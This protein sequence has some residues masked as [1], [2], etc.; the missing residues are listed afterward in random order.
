MLLA[1]FSMFMGIT[2]PFS[3]L[4]PYVFV[5]VICWIVFAAL[6]SVTLYTIEEIYD[7][8]N[9]SGNGLIVAH[10]FPALAF[11]RTTY[12]LLTMS[13]DDFGNTIPS[14]GLMLFEIILF[15]II[16]VLVVMM[17]QRCSR[18]INKKIV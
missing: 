2:V 3:P 13:G 16:A 1:Y 18:I 7:V 10:F 14:I 15:P 12:L 8:K 17:Y 6:P 9:T 5:A 11:L 4:R